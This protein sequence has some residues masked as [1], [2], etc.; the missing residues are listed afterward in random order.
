MNL[1]KIYLASCLSVS[2]LIAMPALASCASKTSSD[3][4]SGY[5]DST[6][7]KEK[8]GGRPGGPQLG[9][10]GGGPVIDKTGDA[11]L[12]SMIKEELP[13]FKQLEYTDSVTGKTMKYS[14]FSPSG[15]DT[16]KE[17]PLVL[18]MADAS[19]PGEDATRPITQGY[20]ALVWATQDWQKQHPCYVL[21]PQFSGVAVN[22]AYQHTDELYIVVRLVKN[23]SASN[24]V[25]SNRIYTTG[26]SMG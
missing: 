19:T 6:M 24:Q 26:Q 12:Q 1:R 25:D 4:A 3:S 21:V 9:T 22:D 13:L 18:F 15:I 17:Y 23:V 10:P 8:R 14:L 7:Q 2:M 11:T 16:S 5:S 20:G